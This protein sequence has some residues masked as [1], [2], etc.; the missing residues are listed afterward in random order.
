MPME[1]ALNNSWVRILKQ[2]LDLVK[3]VFFKKIR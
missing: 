1:T 3:Q 2:S